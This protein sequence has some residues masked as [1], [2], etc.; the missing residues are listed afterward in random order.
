MSIGAKILNAG[1][2][3][4]GMKKKYSL[5]EDQFLAEIRKMNKSRGFYMP[6]DKKAV[7]KEHEVIGSKCLIVQ[8]NEVRAE[9]AILYFSYFAA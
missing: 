1:M 8:R 3:M 2:K 7:Y 6:K 9:K 5:P 4:S